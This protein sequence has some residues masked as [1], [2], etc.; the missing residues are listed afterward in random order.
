MEKKKKE[1]WKAIKKIYATPNTRFFDIYDFTRWNISYIKFLAKHQTLDSLY[2]KIIDRMSTKISKK[3]KYSIFYNPV[4]SSL[5]KKNSPLFS[6]LIDLLSAIF[7]TPA[8]MCRREIGS[9][10]STSVEKTSKKRAIEDRFRDSVSVSP[11]R[12]PK[13]ATRVRSII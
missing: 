6:S 11:I 1:I 2:K 4:I 12:G 10:R 9:T 3:K 7:T 13:L 8:A 5:A